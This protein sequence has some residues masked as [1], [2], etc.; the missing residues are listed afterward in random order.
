MYLLWPGGQEPALFESLVSINGLAEILDADLPLSAVE[1]QLLKG[2][3]S[4]NFG[5]GNRRR[6]P[7][8]PPAP[9]HAP[10]DHG[11]VTGVT[12]AASQ[13]PVAGA[14]AP[15]MAPPSAQVVP[16]QATTTTAHEAPAPASTIQSQAALNVGTAGT[17]GVAA[18]P[19]GSRFQAMVSSVAATGS[20]TQGQGPAM[21]PTVHTT[22]TITGTS[23]LPG[24]T[25]AL[26]GG[27]DA[28]QAST[29]Y[30]GESDIHTCTRSVPT[31]SPTLL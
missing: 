11:A 8:P 4:E 3:T 15:M 26:H 14:M 30:A 29:S 17:S 7:R 31:L 1:R 10:G 20:G 28:G 6:P 12:G 5:G 16:S 2:T 24:G 22:T 23:I 19:E 27:T 13:S 18:T 21:Q 9:T 25:G